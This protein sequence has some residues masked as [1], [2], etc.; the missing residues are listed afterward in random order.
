MAQY[1]QQ[2]GSPGSVASTS[3]TPVKAR[4]KRTL[5]AKRKGKALGR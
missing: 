2:T 5:A 4:G 1:I 3:S